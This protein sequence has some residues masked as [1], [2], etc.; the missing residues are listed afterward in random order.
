[1]ESAAI[2][3]HNPK[4]VLLLSLFATGCASLS[5]WETESSSQGFV[6]GKKILTELI[7]FAPR[8]QVIAEEGLLKGWRRKRI[9][10]GYG[11]KDIVDGSEITVWSCCYRH[12]SGVPLCA[13]HG[14]YFAQVPPELRHGLQADPDGNWFDFGDDWIFEISKDAI[15]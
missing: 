15:K 7:M 10:A 1:M 3:Q 9:S 14:H 8:D 6:D 4:L 11:D 12:N 13:H 5:G 2:R